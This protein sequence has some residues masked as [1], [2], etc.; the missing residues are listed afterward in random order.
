[1][2]KNTDQTVM[3]QKIVPASSLHLLSPVSPRKSSSTSSESFSHEF[4]SESKIATISFQ[5]VGGHRQAHEPT[6]R[7]N[8]FNSTCDDSE[9][10]SSSSFATD[11]GIE[12]IDTSLAELGLA[13]DHFLLNNVYFGLSS[14]EEH[15]TAIEKCKEMILKLPEN[16]E[17]RKKLVNTLVHL[18]HELQEIKD[19]SNNRNAYKDVLNHRLEKK[20]TSNTKLFCDCCSNAIWGMVQVWY[21]CKDCG[22]ACHAKCLNSTRRTCVAARSSGSYNLKICPEAGLSKQSYCCTECKNSIAFGGLNAALLCDYNGLYYCSNCHWNDLAITPARVVQNWDHTPQKV[23]RQSYQFLSRMF[24]RPVLDLENVNPVLFNYVEDLKEVQKM[25]EDILKMKPY[26]LACSSA[27]ELRILCKLQDRQHFVETS[28]MY[29]MKDLSD[30][31]TGLLTPHLREIHGQFVQHIKSDCVGCQ[32]K[33]FICEVCNDGKVLYP[34]D[35]MVSSCPNC[36]A[37]FHS[38]CF[39]I[40][41]ALCP[42]CTRKLIKHRLRAEQGINKNDSDDNENDMDNVSNKPVSDD[43]VS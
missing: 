11:T 42:R 1:M 10:T 17:E 16:S 36:L 25:R 20:K 32:A 43:D 23:C 27:L 35:D 30:I 4:T 39:S 26:F 37:V 9:P 18:R 40:S 24:V 21:Q 12:A 7:I 34:F 8:P 2:N 19:S 31:F 14:V 38:D 3:K 22:Y 28:N 6:K 33:G 15:V 41:H 29:S 13:E 5:E